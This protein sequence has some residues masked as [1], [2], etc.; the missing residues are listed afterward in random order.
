MNTH[1]T[2]QEWLHNFLF[3]YKITPHTTGIPPAEL[4][5]GRQPHSTLDNLQPELC[6]KIENQQQKQKDHHEFKTW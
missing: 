6:N 3:K 1:G 4:L 2:I 5:F